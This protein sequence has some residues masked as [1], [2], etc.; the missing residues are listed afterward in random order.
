DFMIQKPELIKQSLF[1]EFTHIYDWIEL[2]KVVMLMNNKIIFYRVYTEFHAKQVELACALGF[3]NIDKYKEF[4]SSTQ[5]PYYG[6]VLKLNENLST[7]AENY[8]DRFIE[9]P[10]KT[11]LDDFILT[12]FYYLGTASFCKKY[13]SIDY[14]WSTEFLEEFE[15][16]FIDI[17]MD[18]TKFENTKDEINCIA[19]KVI[20]LKDILKLKYKSVD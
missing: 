18:L 4:K 10:N 6:S 3:E 12:T 8:R 2:Q 11:N 9:E 7:E 16:D 19:E 14:L 17:A 1:H 13:C 15:N 5:I 20:K